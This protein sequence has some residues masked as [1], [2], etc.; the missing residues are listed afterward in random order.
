MLWHISVLVILGNSKKINPMVKHIGIV[1]C[2]AEGAALCYR[3]ICREAAEIM[4]RHNHPEITMHTHPLSEYMNCIYQ[5]DWEGVAS[6]MVSSGEIL[7]TAGAS[8]LICPDNTIH[9]VL[10]EVR[11]KS[12]LPWLHIAEEVSKL[13]INNKYLKVLVL[14]TKYLM[15]GPVYTEVFEREGIDYL[16]PDEKT[17]NQ[18]DRIIM[19][20]LVYGV[21]KA[22][23]KKFFLQVIADNKLS[24][25]NAVVLG[26]TEIPLIILPEDS[27]LPVLDSTRILARAAIKEALS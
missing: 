4:G 20:E 6:L 10:P 17:R 26:C 1:A 25:C 8:F 9:Q 12:S 18:I 23:S 27:S 16:I 19:D 7:K 14:G 3:T 5:N 22:E 15:T 2:S 21:I 24:G 11:N 13:I